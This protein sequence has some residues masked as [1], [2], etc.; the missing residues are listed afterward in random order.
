MDL[1]ANLSLNVEKN[2]GFFSL[3]WAPVYH[4]T[5]PSSLLSS[6]TTLLLNVFVMREWVPYL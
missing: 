5:C 6:K 4:A 3:Y 1:A 2:L